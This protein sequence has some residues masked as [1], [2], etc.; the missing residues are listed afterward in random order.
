[1]A[2]VAEAHVAEVDDAV[3]L[4][5]H[6]VGRVHHDLRYRRIG[7]H[8]LYGAEA[9]HLVGYATDQEVALE[10]GGLGRHLAHDGAGGS[11]HRLPGLLRRELFDLGRVHALNEALVHGEYRVPLGVVHLLSGQVLAVSAGRAGHGTEPFLPFA[12]GHRTLPLTH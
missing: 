10:A 3:A 6:V 2:V 12:Y 5:M 7:G 11:L 4:E 1:M 8:L 9:E